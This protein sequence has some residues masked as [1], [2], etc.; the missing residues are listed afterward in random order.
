MLPRCLRRKRRGWKRLGPDLKPFL[1]APSHRS[2][3]AK[4]E[5]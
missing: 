2:E 4:T 5:I 3:L 1:V